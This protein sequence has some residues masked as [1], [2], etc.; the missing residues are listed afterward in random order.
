MTRSLPTPVELA[1]LRVLWNHGPSTVRDI[2]THLHT[3]NGYTTILRAVQIMTDKGFV[4]ANKSTY[5]HV[6][7]ATV[8]ASVMLAQL[9]DDLLQ[10]GF[11]GDREELL[12]YVRAASATQRSKESKS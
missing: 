12:K 1:I 5:A 3:K 7:S 2:H 6:Y 4:T 8:P 10:R 9:V 11:G